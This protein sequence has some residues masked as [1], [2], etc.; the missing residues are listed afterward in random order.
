[1]PA[2]EPDAFATTVA[3]VAGEVA[4]ICAGRSSDVTSAHDVGGGGLAVALA[5]M[6]S[7][8]GVGVTVGELVH[9]AELFA[10]FPGRFVMTTN[11][12]DAFVARARDAGV[13][14]EVLG[15]VGAA[16][17]RIGAFIELDVR[18]IGRRRASAL[19]DALESVG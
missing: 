4:A 1:M 10:E 11:D 5:E 8:N 13:S 17:L 2:F 15:T 3:F 12:P 6:A 14:A 16:T 7:V 19:E 18:E 9:H